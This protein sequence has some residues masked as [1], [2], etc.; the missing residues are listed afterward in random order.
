MTRIAVIGAGSFGKNHVRV[1]RESAR[2]ELA[3]VIDND[4][5]RAREQAGGATASTDY[6]DV[7]GRVDAA[8]LAVPTV[9]HAEVG[10]ALL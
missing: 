3:F 1:V 5:S 10:C 8:I 9:H 6:R 4:E 2:A 7:I